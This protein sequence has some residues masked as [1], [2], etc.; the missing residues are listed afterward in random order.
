MGF[1]VTTFFYLVIGTAVAVSLW[2]NDSPRGAVNLFRT[3]TAPFF[4][5]LYVPALLAGR[6]EASPNL[7][8]IPPRQIQP[9]DE[10]ATLIEKV[11]TELDKALRS[12]NGWAET[13][14]RD[15]Q[16]QIEELRI[17]W[18]HQAD[19]IRELDN[20]LAESSD[21]PGKNDSASATPSEPHPSQT[22]ANVEQEWITPDPVA[23]NTVATREQSR[24]EN[25]IKLKRVRRQLYEDLT[26]TLAWVRELVTMIHLA[27]YTG[28]PAS[29]A[30][31]LV[32][33][34]AAAVEGLTNVHQTSS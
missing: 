27:K 11:E 33:Q 14:L 3:L 20:L 29:R 23:T 6:A 22:S 13:M 28:A 7:T 9:D 32:K 34:I 19:A 21:G 17:A 8:T 10:M 26:A 15:E 4:W 25:V 1:G 31:E 18:R 5:P 2:L 24:R 16:N 12:L 30:V